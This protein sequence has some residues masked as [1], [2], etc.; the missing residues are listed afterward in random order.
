MRESKAYVTSICTFFPLPN[1]RVIITSVC[2]GTHFSVHPLNSVPG[3]GR[4]FSFV[5]YLSKYTSP[6][7]QN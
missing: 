7:L 4:S 6:N 2:Y 5:Q 3:F 1:F